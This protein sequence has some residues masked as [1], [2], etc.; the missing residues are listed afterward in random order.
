MVMAPLVAPQFECYGG[1]LPWL[2]M[3]NLVI[4][5]TVLYAVEPFMPN[6]LETKI[7]LKTKW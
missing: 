2:E 4:N 7:L 3:R 5:H 1:L 6:S